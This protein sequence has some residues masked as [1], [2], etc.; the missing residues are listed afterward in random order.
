MCPPA[1]GRTRRCAPTWKL[2]LANAIIKARPLREK[3]RHRAAD[4]KL[5]YNII[6]AR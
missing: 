6:L 1:K 5:I 2:I 3:P 4:M